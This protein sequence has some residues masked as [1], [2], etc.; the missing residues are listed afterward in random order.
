MAR[1]SP[2][3]PCGGTTRLPGRRARYPNSRPLGSSLARAKIV[4]LRGGR[5]LPG[6]IESQ[7][8]FDFTDAHLVTVLDN[9][10]AEDL[11]EVWKSA[12]ADYF[13]GELDGALKR[14]I[15]TT[16]G[17][18]SG[19]E[20]HWITEWLTRALKKGVA[21]RVEPLG[22]SARDIIEYLPVEAVVPSASQSWA[23]LRAEHDAQLP[24][25]DPTRGLRDF[26]RRLAVRK[27]GDT[28]TPAIE[29]AVRQVT[30]TPEEIR[31]LGLRIREVGLRGTATGEGWVRRE[32]NQSDRWR[33][34]SATS[35]AGRLIGG[36]PWK[37]CDQ[38][39]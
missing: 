4:P 22:L 29:R 31:R 11:R 6:T 32:P 17:K 23:E 27:G 34:F 15:E 35:S 19:A 3:A 26:K 24:N 1:S 14:V 25:L 28:S 39:P 30:E 12:Q 18:S 36:L 9:A 33:S 20:L 7:L 8:L 16:K 2:G 37:R 21:P 13:V 10:R 5:R 38:K